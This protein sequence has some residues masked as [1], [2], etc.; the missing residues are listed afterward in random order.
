VSGG[1]WLPAAAAGDVREGQ[2]RRADLCGQAVALFRVGEGFFATAD[3]CTHAEASL[4]EG[5][6]EGDE[7]ECP[8]HSA[9]FH[10]PTGRAV[11]LPGRDPVRTFPVRQEGA[12]L[13]VLVDSPAGEAAP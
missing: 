5:Y 2:P 9:R 12:A 8:L 7:I 11:A 6:Q 1:R 3:T 10:I 13:L 4:S